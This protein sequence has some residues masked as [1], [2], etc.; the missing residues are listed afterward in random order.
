[1]AQYMTALHTVHRQCIDSIVT[2]GNKGHTHMKISS[3]SFMHLNVYIHST[4][5]VYLY[6]DLSVFVCVLVRAHVAKIA[7]CFGW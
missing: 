5:L 2:T 7:Y 4:Q 6:I 3:A 1:M